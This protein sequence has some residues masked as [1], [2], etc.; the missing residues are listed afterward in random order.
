MTERRSHRSKAVPLLAVPV[1]AVAFNAP[2]S[3]VFSRFW[4]FMGRTP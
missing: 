4:L 2:I 1:L 3:A